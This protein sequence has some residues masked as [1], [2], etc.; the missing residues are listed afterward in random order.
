MTFEWDLVKAKTNLLR[1]AVD[2]ADAVTCFD[3]VHA[4]TVIDPD[5]KTE[6]RY[7]TVAQD[8]NG[9]VLV[10]CFAFRGD[11]IRIISSERPHQA[12]DA[13]MRRLDEK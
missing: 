1:H 8:A 7:L 5:W 11:S 6:E 13:A 10:T 12:S 4:L 3:D 2:F 9:R